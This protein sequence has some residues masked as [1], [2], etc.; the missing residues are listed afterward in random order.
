[1]IS[2]LQEVQKKLTQEK[3]IDSYESTSYESLD[4][5]DVQNRLKIIKKYCEDSED[6][7]LTLQTLENKFL[8]LIKGIMAIRSK[9]D[10]AEWVSLKDLNENLNLKNKNKINV[11]DLENI[12]SLYPSIVPMRR[13]KFVK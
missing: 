13:T 6:I 3:D 8:N 9:K 1:M 11:G 10:H 5:N 2:K 12:C 7:L 4:D